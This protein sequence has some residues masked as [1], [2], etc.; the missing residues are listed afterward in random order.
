MFHVITS[1]NLA[2]LPTRPDR[3]GI[4]DADPSSP[5]Q[6]GLTWMKGDLSDAVA[7]G[8]L[9]PLKELSMS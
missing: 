3:V 1:E 2:D 7:N 6:T 5:W 8:I 9:T 4:E